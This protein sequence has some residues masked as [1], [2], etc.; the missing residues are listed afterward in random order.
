VAAESELDAFVEKVPAT[1]RAF[2]RGYEQ[3]EQA[4]D[5]ARAR[6]EQV[7]GHAART[8]QLPSA[9][10]LDDPDQ[11]ERA[12]RVTLDRLVVARGRGS[13]DDRVSVVWADAVDDGVGVLAA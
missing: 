9:D 5:N 1:S 6:F 7:A 12:L 3:R 8:V 4:L 10:E 2:T 11:F 13:I